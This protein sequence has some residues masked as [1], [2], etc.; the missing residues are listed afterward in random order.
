MTSKSIPT[1]LLL[2]IICLASIAVAQEA[3]PA[4]AAEPAAAAS[5]VAPQPQ[6]KSQEELQAIQA[7][8]SAMDPASRLAACDALIENFPKTEFHEFALQM[9]TISAQMMNDYE[10]MMIYGE[11][12]LAVAPENY[13]VMLAMANGMAQK[14]QKFDLDKEEKLGQ[15]TEFANKAIELIKVAPRP[16]PQITDDMWKEAKRDFTAQGYE[17]LGMIGL[18]RE[19]YEDAVENFK[20]AV[21]VA[22]IPNPATNVRLGAAYNKVGNPGEALATLDAVL[23]DSNLHPQI[24]Q[25]A[26]SERARA[27]K[28]Q[29]E[30]K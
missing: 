30:K 5:P 21:D 25:F 26:Q 27:A 20:K 4:P 14:T 8:Q 12:T 9:A 13:M 28:M 24:R 1:I 19:N 11:R 2:A 29:A 3:Q 10:K 6:I 18:V 16:N 22:V 7:I 17:A 23:A 15:S